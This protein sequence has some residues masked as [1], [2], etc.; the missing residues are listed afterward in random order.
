MDGIGFD[1]LFF[2]FSISVNFWFQ[3]ILTPAGDVGAL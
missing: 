3:G 1:L 2:L